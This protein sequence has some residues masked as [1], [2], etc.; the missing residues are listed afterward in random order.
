MAGKNQRLGHQHH[1]GGGLEELIQVPRTGQK[2][3]RIA[4]SPI[5]RTHGADCHGSVPL[6][7]AA[8]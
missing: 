1:G 2:G 5:E 8:D 7:A 6:E 4:V 3:K